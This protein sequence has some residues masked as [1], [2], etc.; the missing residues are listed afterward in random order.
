MLYLVARPA[1]SRTRNSARSCGLCVLVAGLVFLLCIPG[2]LLGAELHLR[3]SLLEAQRDRVTATVTAVVDHIGAQAHSLLEDCDLHV[4]LRSREIRVA[5][6]REVKNACQVVPKA[7]GLS[8]VAVAG[9]IAQT[10]IQPLVPGDIIDFQ[11]LI[12]MHLPTILDQISSTAQ[13]I[14]LPVEFLFLD[15]E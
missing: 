14:P 7:L 9:T 6:I 1:A 12:R 11:A 13:E 15:L 3:E 4:P 5:F 8:A 10:K 2:Q